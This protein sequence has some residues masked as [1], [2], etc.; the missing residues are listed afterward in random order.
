MLAF[1]L[2]HI[3]DI[4]LIGYG[5][6]TF[7]DLLFLYTHPIF[8]IA[9]VGLVFAVYYHAA[10]GIRIIL[11]DFWRNAYKYERQ[12]FYGAMAVVAL[13]FIPTAIL[14]IRPIF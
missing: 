10:N 13:A 7:N 11:I 9:E 5:E 8:R 4:F 14:M 3:I 1:L 2:L 12:L 6:E